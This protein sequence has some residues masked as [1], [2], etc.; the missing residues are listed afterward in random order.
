VNV[1]PL[2]PPAPLQTAALVTIAWLTPGV[3]G[4]QLCTEH[5]VVA[6]GNGPHA[7]GFVP[8]QADWQLPVPGHAVR[9]GVP[10]V[11]G[12]PAR[13]EQ[14]PVR[15]PPWLH[16]SHWPVHALLQHTVSAQIPLAH[17]A[18]PPGLHSC[19]FF[20]RHTPVPLQML[21]PT[22]VSSCALTTVVQVPGM[23]PLHVW[24]LPQVV[25]PQ[26]T[27]STQWSLAHCAFPEQPWPLMSLQTP[28]PSQ[29][30]A[31][32][33]VSSVALFTD[34]QVPGVVP[35]QV[36]QLPHAAVLQQTWSTQLPL[37]QSPPTLHAPPLPLVQTPNVQF[38][39]TAHA[40][41]LP[42]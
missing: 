13:G 2:Q 41:L 23:L 36:W 14:V 40:G 21:L 10:P 26:H 38:S 8:S 7:F 16:A 15:A 9:V 32:L 6:P 1:A 18:A 27:P 35:L 34:E 30:L 28:P 24:Q 19:P 5:E 25:D 20:L 31:P 37:V 4:V 12:W 39:P 17:E 33:H 22:Q 3:P 29:M 42:H 11:S